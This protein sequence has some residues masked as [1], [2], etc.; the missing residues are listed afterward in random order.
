MV[1]VH[2]AIHLG[3]LWPHCIYMGDSTSFMAQWLT[4]RGVRMIYHTPSWIDPLWR[5]LQQRGGEGSHISRE[6]VAKLW[7]LLDIPIIPLLNFF[8]YVIFSHTDVIFR[9]R[10]DLMQMV[11][12]SNDPE[13][14]AMDGEDAG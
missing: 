9:K 8:D 7:L 3:Y 11:L 4:S 1:A 14:L 2:S 10:I 5:A 6:D 13:C 12:D